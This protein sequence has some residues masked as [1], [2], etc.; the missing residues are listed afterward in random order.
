MKTSVIYKKTANEMHASRP[1]NWLFFNGSTFIGEANHKC[2]Q[3]AW[4][5][6]LE[7]ERI[8]NPSMQVVWADGFSVD[9][10]NMDAI[11]NPDWLE[12]LNK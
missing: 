4:T 12:P 2:M 11:K 6:Y 1:I 9:Q 7:A 10:Y 8:L 3:T 5:L